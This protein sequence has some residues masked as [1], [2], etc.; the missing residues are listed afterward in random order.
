MATLREMKDQ[1]WEITLFCRG[2]CIHSWK[3][4]WD[5]LIQYF[6]PDYDLLARQQ[7][8]RLVCEVCGHRG[9][10]V[11]VHPPDPVGHRASGGHRSTAQPLSVAEATRNELERIAERRR[12]GIKSY[13]ELNAK[14]RAARIAERKAERSGANFIG[15]PSPWKNRKRGRWL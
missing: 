13:E 7:W 3:P 14:S 8:N 12:L 15:P 4:S 10:S 9:A 5:Q 6:G 1:G 11:I 2:Y